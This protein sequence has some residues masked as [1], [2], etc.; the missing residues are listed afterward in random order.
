M[1]E[2]IRIEH[3]ESGKGIF[4]HHFTEHE[5][6]QSFFDRHYNLPCPFSFKESD[7]M[8]EAF[9]SGSND[10]FCA[11]KSFEQLLDWIKVGEFQK[12]IDAGFKFYII[13]IKTCI[14]GNYQAIFKKEDIIE[15][16]DITDL[17]ITN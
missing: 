9:G 11:Y 7:E 17:F 14:I 10:W 5:G 16:I 15:K 2:L 8:K 1:I 12:I 13:Q 4:Q 6:L 3:P